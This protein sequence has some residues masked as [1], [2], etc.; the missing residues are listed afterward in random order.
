MLWVQGPTGMPATHDS[1]N[2]SQAASESNGASKVLET[3]HRPAGDLFDWSPAR[4]LRSGLP[5]T[6]RLHRL[7]MLAGH[8]GP[9]CH[10]LHGRH[11]A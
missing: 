3:S 6:D 1:C 9:A 7:S 2:D 10:E 11:T 4:D 8:I 5:G